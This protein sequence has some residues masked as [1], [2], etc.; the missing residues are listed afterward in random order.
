MMT[1][2]LPMSDT[3][4]LTDAVEALADGFAV[5]DAEG[6]VLHANAAYRDR[7]AG[8]PVP[9]AP[10]EEERE[11]ESGR[12]VRVET[13]AA[14][15]GRTVALCRDVSQDR[16]RRVL[17]GEAIEALDEP[18][19]VF[20]AGERL[21][22]ANAARRS[23]SGAG[24]PGSTLEAVLRAAVAER[25][26]NAADGETYV[27]RRLAGIRGEGPMVEPWAGPDRWTRT[28]VKQLASGGRVIFIADITEL[29][30]REQAL[31]TAQAKAQ[32]AEER[33]TQA[34]EALD[35]AF[36]IRDADE[37]LVICNAAYRRMNLGVPEA[38]TPGQTI[39]AGLRA[40]AARHVH[41]GPER[42][43]RWVEARLD[44]YRSPTGTYETRITSD[45]VGRVIIRTAANGDRVGVT[46]D[47]TEA[48]RREEELE[49]AQAA[50][51]KAEERLT[52]AI[53][54][55]DDA[56]AIRDAEGR[57]VINNAANR[58]MWRQLPSL[59]APGSLLEPGLI[60]LAERYVE[61][62]SERRK[63]WVAERLKMFNSP[64]EGTYEARIAPGRIGRVYVRRPPNGDRV[65][66]VT[67]I[68]ELKRRAE[69]LAL[70]RDAAEEANRAK[71]AF[72]ATVSHEIR[73][74]MNGVLGMMEVL[75]RQGVSE[76]QRQ[77]VTLMRDSANSL[78]R[79]I[80]DI[81]D[82]SKIE[83]GR[84]DLEA[85]P[86]SPSDLIAGVIDTL[87]VRAEA[88]RLAL[89]GH[90]GE[91]MPERLLGDPTR[92]RQILF[93]LVGN[94]LKFT[95]RGFV[96]VSVDAKPSDAGIGL[97]L[98]VEDSGIGMSSDAVGRLFRPFVQADSSTTRRY[99]GSGLGLSIV[100][101]L[102]ELMDGDVKVE[103]VPGRGSIF[104]VTLRL[105]AA[106]AEA[107]A[108]KLV[109][110]SVAVSGR[111]LV[112]DDHP[113]NREVLSRQL[114][115]LGV[116]ADSA[117][118]G[119][120]ALVAWKNGDYA[121]LLVDLNMPVMDGYELARR[122]RAAEAAGDRPRTPIVAVTANALMG[123]SDRCIA[124]GMDAFLTKP[125]TL[126]RLNG[127]LARWMAVAD[128]E[129]RA[130]S[131]AAP[132]F[133]RG[134]LHALF[135]DDRVTVDRL[136]VTFRE[137]AQANVA[138]I[139]AAISRG[140][141]N[142]AANAAHRIKG[143]ARSIGANALADAAQVLEQAGKAADAERAQT[144]AGKL[145]AEFRRVELEL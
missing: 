111:V 103:S 1:R 79:V 109:A 102:A 58:R 50:A 67:D 135:G 16:Q 144:S 49:A 123:E 100:K 134:A 2:I 26:T 138:E 122:V 61:G 86:F 6:R 96:R 17:L 35:D 118:D 23:H 75:E 74:P 44:D 120:Q 99:G 29:K 18:F 42:Q 105:A 36:A 88:K 37:R 80:D 52:Q 60:E 69:E 53:E 59:T 84:L 117:E 81:L 85:I 54:A 112:V 45:R 95:E 108:P 77:S 55:L 87:S 25:F 64:D 27:T 5:F 22:A 124:A 126:E 141:L 48:K 101:R 132:A 82:F 92:I 47:V 65:T 136:L 140:D 8:V 40:L 142:T 28:E 107:P 115:L 94:A 20:D 104:T 24:T 7:F 110:P 9:P 130:D 139:D 90:V 78:L 98:Q 116:G 72:L 51:R 33:L 10:G 56:F 62:T 129:T 19:S 83:A 106:P 73:T 131:G 76:D 119:A 89:I 114:A 125:T 133:D 93:N 91:S 113:V 145:A 15:P 32:R 11:I 46:R 68:T 97:S 127:I 21:V 70:A 71:S 63:Q 31:E 43:A 4:L 34:I 13:R 12:W 137:S 121:A 3:G 38:T 14:G 30:R 143:A 39:E 41:G 128:A 57:L 66:V